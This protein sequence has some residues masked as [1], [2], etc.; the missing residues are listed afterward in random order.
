M[1]E[2]RRA[3]FFVPPLPFMEV[4]SA[5]SRVVALAPSG[6][7]ADGAGDA[8]D[9]GALRLKLEPRE[10]AR[11]EHLEL[12]VAPKT[13]QL[14]GSVLVDILGNRTEVRFSDL[15]EN[16]GVADKHFTIE[17]PADTEVIDLR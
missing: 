15:V 4:E 5:W 6:P 1:A 10:E 7:G 11:F 9:D 2:N 16:G 3:W 14:R 8:G 17:V 12:W 13:H